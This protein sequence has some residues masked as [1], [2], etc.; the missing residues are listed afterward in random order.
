[1]TATTTLPKA[2][3]DLTSTS[4]SAAR[5]ETSDKKYNMYINALPAQIRKHVFDKKLDPR[6]LYNE[7][8]K[9]SK[10]E[11]IKKYGTATPAAAKS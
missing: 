3:V 6:V 7:Y 8:R 9:S 5:I 10:D 11:M 1:M 2:P 4:R